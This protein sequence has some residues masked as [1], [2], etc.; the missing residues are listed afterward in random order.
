MIIVPAEQR[1]KMQTHQ[2]IEYT[3][4]RT[5]LLIRSYYILCE[6]KTVVAGYYD[7]NGIYDYG[8][9]NCKMN[10]KQQIVI[11]IIWHQNFTSFHTLATSEY[12][13]DIQ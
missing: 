9:V 13:K 4:W 7:N 12:N 8:P 3:G 2:W 1:I 10:E 5:D 6:F 11:I